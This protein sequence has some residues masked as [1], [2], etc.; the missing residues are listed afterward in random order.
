LRRIVV[1]RAPSRRSGGV[2][3][4]RHLRAEAALGRA[5]I[6]RW[7]REGDGRTPA[8]RFRLLTVYYRPDRLRRPWTVLPVV[9]IRPD[10]GWCDDP[11]DRRYNRPVRLPYPARH[12]RLWRNDRLYDIVVVLDFNLARPRAGA[13]SAIFLHLASPDFDPTEGCIAVSETKMRRILARAGPRTMVDV[14]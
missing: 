7:K 11:A 13:G 2:I 9:A 10:L 8:G 4:A 1:R 3:V 5:S 6:G 14:R 12:E